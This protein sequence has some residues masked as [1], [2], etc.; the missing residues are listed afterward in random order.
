[1]KAHTG[2][3]RAVLFPLLKKRKKKGQ[4]IGPR[5]PSVFLFVID[6]GPGLLKKAGWNYI[7]APATMHKSREKKIL[8]I[9][10]R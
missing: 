3:W 6:E 1:M 4:E 10:Y 9:I 8:T 5:H 2:L 7:G